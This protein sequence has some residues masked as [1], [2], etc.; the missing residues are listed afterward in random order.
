[1]EAQ[2]NLAETQ[3]SGPHFQPMSGP[4]VE[5]TVDP[6]NRFARRLRDR[7]VTKGRMTSHRGVYAGAQEKFSKY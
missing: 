2:R 3:Q 7:T 6:N 1:M 5:D 4:K